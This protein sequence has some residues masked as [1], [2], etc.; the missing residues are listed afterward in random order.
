MACG[1]LTES[2]CSCASAR[3]AVSWHCQSSIQMHSA[4]ISVGKPGWCLVHLLISPRTPWNLRVKDSRCTLKTFHACCECPIFTSFQESY[5]F[6]YGLNTHISSRC[7]PGTYS[8]WCA[9]H[10]TVY[11]NNLPI[12]FHFHVDGDRFSLSLPLRLITSWLAGCV[13]CAT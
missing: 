2:R 6:G 8:R 3:D 1:S 9:L 10:D 5:I 4:S 11:G 7:F 13:L 12:L